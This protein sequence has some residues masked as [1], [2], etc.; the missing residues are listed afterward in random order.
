MDARTCLWYAVP[1][2]P[3]SQRAK[4]QLSVARWPVEWPHCPTCG[5]IAFGPI[6]LLFSST[7]VYDH[8]SFV[9][10]HLDHH[11]RLLGAYLYRA[12]RSL[13]RRA[14]RLGSPPSRT[15]PFDYPSHLGHCLLDPRLCAQRSPSRIA[16]TDPR[17][18]TFRTADHRKRL[19]GEDDA[20]G[21]RC[22]LPLRLGRL[23]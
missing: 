23:G 9:A 14:G 22:R 7:Q 5:W 20:R 6:N 2:F 8:F 10:Y 19:A 12:G 3:R 11:A 13:W 1:P 4:H 18:R 16:R 15:G 17:H 21:Q